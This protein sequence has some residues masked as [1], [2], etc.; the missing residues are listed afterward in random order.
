M[1]KYLVFHVFENVMMKILEL[2]RGS[3]RKTEEIAH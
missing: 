3:N 1:N 2:R